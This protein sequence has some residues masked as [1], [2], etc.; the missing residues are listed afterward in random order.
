MLGWEEHPGH[1]CVALSKIKEAQGAWLSPTWLS[2]CGN[3]SLWV[4]TV[5]R[6]LTPETVPSRA[7]CSLVGMTK[8]AGRG[9]PGIE[10]AGVRSLPA[11][12]P[13]IAVSPALFGF[14]CRTTSLSPTSQT[15]AAIPRPR[16]PP[17]PPRQRRPSLP[18]P[19]RLLPSTLP[20]SARG[21]RRTSTCQV[22]AML[23]GVEG[24]LGSCQHH[25]RA[26]PCLKSRV[27]GM[28]IESYMQ[29]SCHLI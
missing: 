22:P 24:L 26:W 27:E 8:W 5:D 13:L 4:Q 21:S 1:L 28:W 11:Q 25:F 23:G 19:H 9:H 7:G 10:D 3:L 16:R 20:R 12:L 6:N 17:P 18:A 15:R 14:S 2:L 29:G